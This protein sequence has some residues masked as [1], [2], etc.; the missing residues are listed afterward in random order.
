MC[1][2]QSLTSFSAARAMEADTERLGHECQAY[3]CELKAGKEHLSGLERTL[4]N[5]MFPPGF[6]EPQDGA[7]ERFVYLWCFISIISCV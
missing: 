5:G 6:D 7:I 4:A 1:V 3:Q 2:S